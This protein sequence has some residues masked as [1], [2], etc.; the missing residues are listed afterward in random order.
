MNIYISPVSGLVTIWSE[1]KTGKTVYQQYM[2][3]T[4]KESMRKFREKFPRKTRSTKGVKRVDWFP[5]GI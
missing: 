3:Y 2:G 1:L 5:F 4:I